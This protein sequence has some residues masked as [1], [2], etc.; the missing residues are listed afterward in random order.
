MDLVQVIAL[1]LISSFML[2]LASAEKTRVEKHLRTS[3]TGWS[4]PVG[5]IIRDRV[6]RNG[7]CDSL[8]EVLRKNELCED[9]RDA[10]MTI[11]PAFLANDIHLPEPS[12]SGVATF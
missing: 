5:G 12:T 7:F 3:G 4:S 2:Q 1:D 6:N 11:V 10:V 9:M 8:A